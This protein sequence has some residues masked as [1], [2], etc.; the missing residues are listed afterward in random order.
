MVATAVSPAPPAS[1]ALLP[2]H[3]RV[4]S[5]LNGF[6]LAI[7]PGDAP[8]GARDH[9]VVDGAEQIGPVLRGGFASAA[10]PEQDRLVTFGDIDLPGTQ[11]DQELIHTDS[12][13]ARPP[14]AVDQHLK[15]PAERPE[16]AI[17]VADRQECQSGVTL[18]D[19]G[20]P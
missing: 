20:V 8:A 15:S 14:P 3:L 17:R 10:R 11:V 12:S 2:W 4:P 18:R 1:Q 16:H 19:P 9:F 13:D 5:S 6:G 7:G